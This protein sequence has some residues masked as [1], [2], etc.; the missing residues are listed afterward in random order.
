MGYWRV[1]QVIFIVGAAL[2]FGAAFFVLAW[3]GLP[4]RA[5]YSGQAF[6]EIGYAA[7]EIGAIAP[8]FM[9]PPLN[10]D[11]ID[12]LSLR[13]EPVII[14]FWAS[15][16]EPCQAEMPELE[17]LHEETGVKILAVNIG[18]DVETIAAWVAEYG[19]SFDI[20][21]DPNEELY[22]LYRL[23]GQPSTYVLDADGIIRQIFYGPTSADA[24]RSALDLLSK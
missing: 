18:E 17:L 23:R 19:L 22:A 13:G 8:P 24:L 12:L 2:C 21:L 10:G 20:V 3:A 6:G 11:E 4:N 16:C 7:P 9:H 1:K 14:N 15:W 5:D